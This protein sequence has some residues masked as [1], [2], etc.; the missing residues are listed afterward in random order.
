MVLCHGK[1]LPR[2]RIFTQAHAVRFVSGKAGEANQAPSHIV[3]TFIRK[4][5]PHQMAATA[6]ND[7]APVLGILPER[8]SL[9]RVDLVPDHA[10]NGHGSSVPV[11]GR[12]YFV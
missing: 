9:E 6:R 3:R 10:D 2:F 12:R 5:V 11:V 8:F 7:T 1:I 4:E